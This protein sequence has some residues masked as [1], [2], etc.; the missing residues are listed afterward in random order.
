MLEAGKHIQ[1]SVRL[2][3]LLATLGVLS[4]MLEERERE[5]D[6]REKRNADDAHRVYALG[7]GGAAFTRCGL[8]HQ[9][10]HNLHGTNF[11]FNILYEFMVAINN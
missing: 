7:W 10:E 2:S 5:R 1:C 9:G 6:S 11:G 3:K 4:G 8:S